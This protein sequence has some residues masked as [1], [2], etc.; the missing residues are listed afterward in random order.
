MLLSPSPRPTM[1]GFTSFQ[2]LMAAVE[3]RHEQ[4]ERVAELRWD[5]LEEQG[6][7]ALAVG[8]LPLAIRIGDQLLGQSREVPEE[9]WNF[10]N[11]MHHGHIIK[12]YALLRADDI[13]GAT[14]ELQ[15]AGRTPGSPQLNSFGPDIN[16]A[17]ELLQRG[18]DQAV[19]AYFHDISRFWSPMG[20]LQLL[21]SHAPGPGGPSEA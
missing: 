10:G 5:G 9:D 16:L 19:L 4:A 2:L 20:R 1:E 13:E 14:K 15:A 12:G 18:R 11:L 21:E 17:W 7:D 3:T 8:D 6:W